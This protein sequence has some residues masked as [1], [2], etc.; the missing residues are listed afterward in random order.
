MP[1]K[2]ELAIAPENLENVIRVVRGQRVM[3]D[4]DPAH[5]G[6]LSSWRTIF[7]MP[8]CVPPQ[9]IQEI[10]R[11]REPIHWPRLKTAISTRSSLAGR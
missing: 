1:R 10:H 11:H 9:F 5:S 6:T 8:D 3:L 2:I 4:A 7:A